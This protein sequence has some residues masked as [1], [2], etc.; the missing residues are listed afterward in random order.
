MADKRIRSLDQLRKIREETLKKMSIREGKYRFKITIPM[1]TSG[2][3]AGAREVM[4]AFLEAIEVHDLS[5]VIVSQT[6][7]VGSR[8]I[9]PLAIVE[10][11][12][13]YKVA[14]GNLTPEKAKE[15]VE[16][17]ILK[18]EKVREYVVPTPLD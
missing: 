4:K 12:E 9:Q 16:K 8:N 17:H 7:F 6:G 13:G 14:Y 1:G 3:A 11:S 2:I 18:G 10:D 15:I 5:D